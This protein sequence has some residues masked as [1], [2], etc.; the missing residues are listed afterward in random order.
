MSP[1][2]PQLAGPL[3]PAHDRDP[4]ASSA[5]PLTALGLPGNMALGIKGR[6]PRARRKERRKE[7]RKGLLER[8]EGK[9]D[10]RAQHTEV[11]TG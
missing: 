2:S 9:R 11:G 8:A 1:Q 4:E 10:G 7:G 5:P 3:L 6:N